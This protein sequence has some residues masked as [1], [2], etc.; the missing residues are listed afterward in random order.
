MYAKLILIG[1]LLIAATI[2]GQVTASGDLY[3][4][5]DSIITTLPDVDA[6]DI[7][8]Y[9]APTSTEQS[10]WRTIIQEMLDGDYATAHSLAA[11]LDYRVV[12]FSDTNETPNDVYYILERTPSSTENY[13]G[14]F[15]VN[16]DPARSRLV[17]QA[18]HPVQNL[19]TGNQAIRVYKVADAWFF[20]LAGTSK[21]NATGYSSCDGTSTSCSASAEPYRIC[22]QAHAVSATF[23]LTTEELLAERP[24][25]IVLQPHGYTKGAGGPDDPDIIMSNGS[26]ATPPTAYLV[27]L[28]NNI[29][30]IDGSLTFK[31]AHIDTDYTYYLGRENVQGRLVNGAADPCEDPASANTGNFIHLEQAYS[32]LRE[33][34]TNWMKLATAVA[35]TFATDLQIVSAQSGSWTAP[36]TWVGGVVPTQ[37]DNVLIDAG[38]V[39]SV[40][41]YNAVCLDVTFGDTA[42]HIDM[43]AN[44][45]LSVYGNFTLFDQTH[46]V[47]SAGWSATDATIRFAGSAAVQTLSGWST[48]GGSTSFRDMIIDKSPGAVVQTGG[49]GMRFGVQNSLTITSGV[50]LLGA[51][52]DFEAR[53]ASS[54]LLTGNQNLTITVQADGE[55]R[56]VNGDGTHWMRSETG[57]TP[58][59]PMTVYGYAE[60]TDAS[61]SDISLQS[62]DVMDGGTLELGLALGSSTYG[63]EFNPGTIT[64]HDGGSIYCITTTDL[65]FAGTTVTLNEGGEYKTIASTTVFPPVF[66]NNGKVRYQRDGETVT[67]QEIADMDYYDVE[68]SFDGNDHVKLWD[69]TANRAVADSLTINNSADLSLTAASPATLSIAQTLRLTSG[70][71]DNSDADVTIEMGDGALISRATGTISNSPTYAGV[72]DVR[73]TST[74]TSVTTGPEMPSSSTALRDL[75]VYSSGQ[76]VTLDKDIIVNGDLTLSTG[77]FDNDGEENDYTMTMADGTTIRRATGELDAVPTFAGGVNLEYI[78]TVGHVTTGHE[79]PSDPATLVNVTMSGNQGITLGDDMTVNGVLAVNGSDMYTDSYAI[80][81]A[82]GAS[83][84]EDSGY[85]V[86]GTV[87]ATKTVSQSVAENFAGLGLELTAAS[88]EPGTT[89]VTRVTNDPQ[90]IGGVLGIGRYFDISA[91]NNTG[92]GATMV[93]HYDESELNGID[94]DSLSLYSSTDGGFNWTY[95]GGT[96]DAVNNTITLAGIG[97]FSMWTAGGVA[98]EGQAIS[99]QSGSWTD[100][101]TW[102]GGAIPVMDDDVL[103]VSGHTISV[104]DTN[105][106]CGN[107]T[108]GGDDALIDMNADSRLTIYGDMT[109]FS[110]A[111]NVFSAGW[112]ATNAYVYFAGGNL[113]TLSG[114]STTAGSTSFRDV[115]IAKDSGTVVATGGN[116]MR[117]GIQNSLNIISGEFHLADDDDFEARW[118][119]SANLTGNQDLTITVGPGAVFRMID[120]NGTHWMRSQTG[121]TPTGPMT[122]YGEAIFTDASSS[123][124]SLANID[125]KAGGQLTLSLGLGS[126]TYG[127]EFNP[128]TVT[129]DSGG[130]LFN[131]TTSDL[132]FDTSIVILSRGGIYK[133]TS[134]TTP[135]PPT[136]VNDGRVRYQRN[137]SS[138]TTDQE[139]V[140][141]DYFDIEFSFN[142]NSTRKLWDLTGN[143]LVADSLE[144]NNS[145]EVIITAS[146]AQTLTIDSTLRLTSGSIDNSDADVTMLMSDGALISRATGT[147]SSAPSFAGVVDIR[148][149][150]SVESVTTGPELPTDPGTIRDLTIYSSDQT[151]TL[152]ADA[153]VNREL[154][155]SVGIFDN[156]GAANDKT[157]TMADSATIRRA[158]GEL[159]AAP[160]FGSTVHVEY[161][162]VVGGVTTG[163]ELPTGT[164]VL[165]DLR[166]LG[167]QGVTMGQDVTVNG[168]LHLA[169]SILITDTYTITLA[170]EAT[171]VEDSIWVVQGK[172]QTTHD[173]AQSVADD[174]GGLGLTVTAN[175]AA[176]GSTSVL[177][178][179]GQAV[180]V[181]GGNSILRRFEVTPTVNTALNAA[182]T[183]HYADAELNGNA[184]AELAMYRS[185][186]GGTVW[187]SLGGIVDTAANTVTI[188]GVGSLGWL[189]L[190]GPQSGCCIGNTGNVNNDA[191]NSVDLSDLIYLVNY[192]F[193][194]GPAP[195]CMASANVN[196]DTG[197]SVD[198]SDLIYLVNYLF[199]GGPSPAACLPQCE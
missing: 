31:V 197:C 113:Q 13:W 58:I 177:R 24:S 39:I 1:M 173:V 88:A 126:T 52:D 119:S 134:S 19:N 36:A 118:A 11:A 51:D 46:N 179:T 47:F 135:W 124:I 80:T 92:L 59:G 29:A 129:I 69:L 20:C 12:E 159:T 5:I 38:H 145:A 194:G 143:R 90:S 71:I 16:P 132:W 147:I 77:V 130:V 168:E 175:G 105:A 4:R 6:G 171:I 176:P 17:I 98:L 42:S 151:V 9:V 73:Y 111:H 85:T 74:T 33:N 62:I 96:V 55:F 196:G 100:P 154:T 199:L 15:V 174:F 70:T 97:S 110:E 139:V 14:T 63:P 115:V 34:E 120:G 87:L 158:T 144:V 3:D 133:S 169:D 146:T 57:S 101:A 109:L 150:S 127:P 2:S 99:A 76:V 66:N 91:A 30:A 72:V 44:S 41:D 128:G 181:G 160:A 37:N 25:A 32:G 65:W 116:G 79:V 27:T 81:L 94:E 162:S 48:T 195:E 198:L 93:F 95:R 49:N 50:F 131:E 102:V 68:F 112:S 138:A 108:F 153:T 192:L 157:L 121:S 26:T 122:I 22:D 21:C 86:K 61:S 142:G 180:A 89:T 104:D 35:N 186:D 182:L 107:L 164:T 8:K 67:D 183:F 43:N 75:T 188:D 64:V 45:Q 167:N 189:T 103:I 149:T 56:F 193:L 83:I 190:G 191:G 178:V 148:Y 125:V 166:I 117:L 40:D 60:F 54:G 172:V 155:L 156:N 140:D 165:G 23:Q 141:V 10:Q 7:D 184:E 28:R 152:A 170:P 161:I 82:D 114:W 163:P 53:W 18:P 106:V 185:T 84:V 123:D 78:S 137:P 136:I 187:E